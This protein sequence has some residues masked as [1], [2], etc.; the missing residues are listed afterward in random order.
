[1]R[2][3]AGLVAAGCIAVAACPVLAAPPVVTSVY[4]ASQRINA[5]R[6]TVIEAHFDQDIDPAT[7]TSLS[8]RAYGRW[9][10]PATG[11]FTVTGGT[12]SFTPSEPFFAGEWITVSMSKGIANTTGEHLAKGYSWNFWIATATGTLTLTYVNRISVR[13]PPETW[14]QV[15]GAY[16]G[17]LNNDGWS[18]LIAP[19][20]QTDDARV[21]LSNAGTFSAPPTKVSLVN[22]ATPSPNEGADFDNDGEIDLVVGNTGGDKASILFGDGTGNFPLAR[23]TS[24]TC[25]NT[26]RGV[27]VGDFNGDGWDDFV[28]ANRFANGGA[29]NLSIVLNNGDGTFATPVTK[30]TGGQGEY[31][32]A[33]ADANNDGIPDIFC[34]TFDSTPYMIVLLGDGD[35][36]FTAQPQVNEGGKPWQTVV[37]DFNNDGNVDVASCN[38]NVN[39]I[40]ILFGNGAGGFTGSVTTV[41]CDAFPLAIDAGDIDGDGDLELVTSNYNAANWN[42]FQNTNGTFGHKKVLNASSAGSCA[43]LHDRD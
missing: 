13:I 23:R 32:I 41:A 19:C 8:F 37:G 33:I 1:M 39:N 24:V 31:T 15:Y 29:G 14:V 40:G 11:S 4:P 38:S 20:E 2:H 30:E 3:L 7:V 9:S 6:N 35:G 22:G 27:G 26:V 34:G 42:I 16:A 17:D 36:G 28:T 43:V 18:D 10:G 12:I 5:G 21:F 25:G